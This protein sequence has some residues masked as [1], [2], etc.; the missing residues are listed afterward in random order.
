MLRF[1]ALALLLHLHLWL[2]SILQSLCCLCRCRCWRPPGCSQALQLQLTLLTLITKPTMPKWAVLLALVTMP[3]CRPLPL[4]HL[5][6]L[7]EHLARQLRALAA[8]PCCSRTVELAGRLT[9]THE[10]DLPAVG[11]KALAKA[12]DA[13]QVRVAAAAVA[14]Q[15][16]GLTLRARGKASGVAE[17]LKLITTMRMTIM[18]TTRVMMTIVRM[19]ISAVMTAIVIMIMMMMGTMTAT[20]AAQ[21]LAFDPAAHPELVLTL[22]LGEA[23][24]DL[25]L[26]VLAGAGMLSPRSGSAAAALVDSDARRSV[27]GL[28]VLALHCLW[29]REQEQEQE[30]QQVQERLTKPQCRQL[31]G[32]ARRGPATAAMWSCRSCLRTQQVQALV[33]MVSVSTTMTMTM[34]MAR[35]MLTTTII[36]MLLHITVASSMAQARAAAAGAMM[37]EGE[38]TA[39]TLTTT[40]APILRAGVRIGRTAQLH[41]RRALAGPAAPAAA[42]A[43]PALVV[44]SRERR[45]QT[46]AALMTRTGHFCE[47]K[48]CR[49]RELHSWLPRSCVAGELQKRLW[50]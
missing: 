4:H 47:A 12:L 2:P 44:G 48:R 17:T 25:V 29:E 50:A 15:V 49:L 42:P 23:G 11:A 36:V 32:A 35:R 28:P 7:R 43:V 16:P 20:A 24:R 13:V 41:G 27:G 5:Q 34:V 40:G 45:C 39:N 46:S 21:A 37:M 31:Q 3:L 22:A 6:S 1:S 8:L 18:R 10:G 19:G 30:Q 33:N 9:R 26:P 38:A 14:P